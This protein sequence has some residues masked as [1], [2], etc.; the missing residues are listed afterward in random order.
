M[1]NHDQDLIT[2]QPPPVHAV[3]ECDHKLTGTGAVF[4]QSS[5]WIYCTV[6]GGWQPIRRPIK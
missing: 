6:C 1:H 3:C 2:T 5:G 4:Y